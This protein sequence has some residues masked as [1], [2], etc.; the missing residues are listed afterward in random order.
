[1]PFLQAESQ[2]A[3]REGEDLHYLPEMQGRV[4]QK[5]L[6]AGYGKAYDAVSHSFFI[7]ASNEENIHACMDI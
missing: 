6:K 4:Y 3:E 7:P 2:G 5:E 1:M